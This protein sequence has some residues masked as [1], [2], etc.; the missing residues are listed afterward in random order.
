MLQFLR[1]WILNIIGLAILLLLLEILV[2]SGRIK[3]FVSLISGFILIIAVINPFIG[4][5]SKGINLQDLQ[6]ADG[7]YI[8]KKELEV[9]SKLFKEQQ[10]KQIS[11]V[12]RKKIIDRLELN[13]RGVEGVSDVRA[14]V[15]INEDYKSDSFGE[16]RRVYLELTLGDEVSGV[17][18]VS[19]IER[20]E[21]NTRRKEVKDT[22]SDKEKMEAADVQTQVHPELVKKME[23]RIS[24]SLGISEENIV[25]SV[26]K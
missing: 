1:G 17:K 2:P 5:F 16:I 24:E 7:S 22:G 3:K 23:G 13:A 20:V 10:M 12:Y 21:I 14:D 19:G 15:I 4:L 8:D 6:M 9:N 25:I 26:K 11:Q 18:P